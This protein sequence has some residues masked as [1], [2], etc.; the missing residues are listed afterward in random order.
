MVRTD[1]VARAII[2]WCVPGVYALCLMAWLLS[3]W[4]DHRRLQLAREIGRIVRQ[5]NPKTLKELE[6]C[7]GNHLGCI[8]ATW[9][10]T[11]RPTRRVA[12]I[13]LK[14]R[15]WLALSVEYTPG[16][17]RIE[18]LYLFAFGSDGVSLDEPERVLPGLA[19]WYSCLA[20]VAVHLLPALLWLR[21][22]RD[23]PMVGALRVI[24]AM[25]TVLLL[26]PLLLIAAMALA[27]MLP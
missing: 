23:R 5:E 18:A 2:R 26:I 13:D 4:Q 6:T 12:Q 10:P 9:A 14:P 8:R 3:F 15:L 22:T 21:V 11:N 17:D 19:P 25:S 1:K 20:L 16:P 27:R 24:A 7:L